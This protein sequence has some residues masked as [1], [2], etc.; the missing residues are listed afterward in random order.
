M[1][2]RASSTARVIDLHCTAG[3][4]RVSV[5][6]STAPRATE[7]NLGLLYSAKINNGP[8]RCPDFG[9]WTIKFIVLANVHQHE[10]NVIGWRAFPPGSHAI[11]NALF[12]FVGRQGRRL[13]DNFLDAFDAEH[14]SPGIENLGDPVGI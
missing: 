7:S 3:K 9:F 8:P 11:E 12:H 13:T 14:L 5:K 6:R 1:L 2:V 10:R 4:P